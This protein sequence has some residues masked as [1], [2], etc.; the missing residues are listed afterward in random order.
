MTAAPH[1]A[2]PHVA[3]PLAPLPARITR[4]RREAPEVFTW[5]LRPAGGF[6]FAPG[7]FNMLYVHG[8]GEVPISISGDP[9]EPEVLVHTIRAVGS[10]TRLME[11]LEAG[12]AVG[13]RGPYGTPWPALA[14]LDGR[15]VV[16]VAGGIGLAP[17]RPSLYQLARR[18]SSQGRAVLIAGART[19]A[20]LLYRRQVEAWAAEGALEL[21][22]TVDRASPAW[23][24]P[25]GF[26]TAELAALDLDP[27]RTSALVCGPEVMMR[28]VAR[29]LIRRGVAPEQVWLTTERN[30]RCA[31][32]TCGHCQLGPEFVCKDGPVFPYPRLARWLSIREV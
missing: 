9:D 16:V 4:V 21:Y 22:Q 28:S 27:E 6:P 26:V 20:D 3:E 2:A 24:G 25:V 7:Q 31:V 8:A 11:R 14:D 5:T 18:P 29:D 23:S 17:L 32:G 30:M 10:V 1:T 19:D 13:V 12:A 15:D